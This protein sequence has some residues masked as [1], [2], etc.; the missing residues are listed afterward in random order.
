M[1]KNLYEHELQYNNQYIIYIIT[2]L[3]NYYITLYILLYNI[4]KLYFTILFNFIS[5]NKLFFVLLNTLKFN[6]NIL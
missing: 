3:F 6:K 5:I 2:N 1:I 4:I